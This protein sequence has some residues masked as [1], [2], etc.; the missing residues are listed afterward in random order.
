[1]NSVLALVLLLAGP[2]PELRQAVERGDMKALNRAVY[3]ISREAKEKLTPE[4]QQRIY[5]DVLREFRT[6]KPSVP[7]ATA[8]A[9][10][11]AAVEE[12]RPENIYAKATQLSFAAIQ[13]KMANRKDPLPAFYEA[14]R[15]AEEQPEFM[16]FYGLAVVA[17]AAQ[18]HHEAR[19]AA[20]KA[21]DT[22][23][24]SLV[25]KLRA[26]AAHSLALIAANASWELGDR[27]AAESY[28][29]RSLDTE[30]LPLAKTCPDFYVAEKL[31]RAEMRDAVIRY[32]EKAAQLPFPACQSSIAQWIQD[33]KQGKQP[34]F[35]IP[36]NAMPPN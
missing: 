7:L 35:M 29:L 25:G 31:L 34:N 5:A 27:A 33:L 32:F 26:D 36:A 11:E 19:E 21:L 15:K 22:R 2:I 24:T 13:Q 14:K 12:R 28:L 17:N 20:Q 16:N 3:R 18:Q 1:M 10:L 8:L 6:V 23:Q 4:Q 9:Q 30:G